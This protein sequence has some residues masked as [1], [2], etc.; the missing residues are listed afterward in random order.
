MA[1]P[2]A[3]GGFSTPSWER[4]PGARG[5]QETSAVKVLLV[6]DWLS[7]FGGA[8]TA[9]GRIARA[10]SHAGCQVVIACARRPTECVSD[11]AD[12]ECGPGTVMHK[13]PSIFYEPQLSRLRNFLRWRLHMARVERG[14]R[15]TARWLRRLCRRE[16]P[17]VAHVCN[18]H[19]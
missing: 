5:I 8:P 7:G 18:V 13:L 16:R 4:G 11:D 17:D 14:R 6:N 1:E 9:V 15:K 12:P 10:L 19:F 3:E 2:G